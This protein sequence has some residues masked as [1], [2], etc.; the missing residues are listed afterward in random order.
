MNNPLPAWP[1]KADYTFT[2]TWSDASGAKLMEPPVFDAELY[3]IVLAS[4]ALARLSALVSALTAVTHAPIDDN[5]KARLMA[6]RGIAL[7]ALDSIGPLPSELTEER[8]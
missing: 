7:D 3:N 5:A 1:S 4:A 2:H 6:L 8:V